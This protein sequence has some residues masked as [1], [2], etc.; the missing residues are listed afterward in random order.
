MELKRMNID[1]IN[2]SNRKRAKD[3]FVQHWGSPIMVI[4]SGT[5]NCSELEGYMATDES[6]QTIGLITYMNRERRFEILSL[7]SMVEQRGVGTALM[8]AVETLAKQKG[9][10]AIHLVTT[11]DNLHALGFYQ[12]RGYVLYKLHKDAVKKARLI[13]PEIPFVSKNQIP[14]RDEIECVK[15]IV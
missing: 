14:I 8:V 6:G 4:A 5:Y 2:E 12:K 11:N 1:E 15:Y 7:D 10:K 3:F 9:A 13:K